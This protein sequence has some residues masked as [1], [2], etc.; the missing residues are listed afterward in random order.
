[1]VSAFCIIFGLDIATTKLRTYHFRLRN[2]NRDLLDANR[3][4]FREPDRSID[5]RY[6]ITVYAG[7]RMGTRAPLADKGKPD[8]LPW[9]SLGHGQGQT[10]LEMTREKLDILNRYH[11]PKGGPDSQ[12]LD[13]LHPMTISSLIG[14]ALRSGGVVVPPGEHAELV[15]TKDGWWFSSLVD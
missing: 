12:K 8:A 15:H 5:T 10:I 7:S 11:A 4:L 14:S 3:E 2:Q 13:G 9:Y 6:Y 1:M